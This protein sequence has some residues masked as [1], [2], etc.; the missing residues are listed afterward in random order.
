MVEEKK[1]GKFRGAKSRRKD[2]MKKKKPG[3]KERG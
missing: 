1:K 2:A 3:G